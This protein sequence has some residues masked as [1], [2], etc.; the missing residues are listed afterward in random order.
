MRF[1]WVNQNQTFKQEFE[2]GYLWSPKRKAN[3]H[4]N[5]FYDYMRDVA[6]GDV[7]FSFKA[8]RIAAIGV[9]LSTG[10]EAP[11][12]EEFGD[13]GQN[14]SKIGWK[15]HVRY[16]QLI[17]SIRPAEHMNLIAPTLPERYSPLLANGNGLQSVYLAAVPD[18]MAQILLG[19]IGH[20][21]RIVVD[22]LQIADSTS[23]DAGQV[24][25][26]VTQWE[27][28]LISEVRKTPTISDTERTA[29]I[30]A[31]RGQ[32]RFRQNVAKIEKRCR[33]TRVD[34]R[35]H[36]VASHTK[37]WRD[38]DTNEERLDGHNGLLLTP[39]ID[40]LFDRGF[41][42]FENDGKLL[43]S[44]VV[45][46]ESVRRMGIVDGYTNV[47]G[48]SPEQARYLEFHRDQVFL[49]SGLGRNSPHG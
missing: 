22:Q 40:H 23:Y 2:G 24:P 19:I 6:P 34:R 45:H 31:R 26:E 48:F 42:S 27:E 14:W 5:A 10:F 33:V 32:G 8:T 39:T 44:P 37:P 17:N 43:I 4:R 9:A 11:K 41:I 21:A 46:R 49:D 20:E 35:E 3:G 12:P 18:S 25:E 30:K 38:C 47:G 7:V 1:W 36:L 28:H 29:I 15:V 13:S 16:T